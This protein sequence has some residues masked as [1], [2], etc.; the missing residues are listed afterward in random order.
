[1]KP[2]KLLVF[3]SVIL[4][5]AGTSFLEQNQPE[6][7][8]PI[9]HEQAMERWLELVKNRFKGDRK[10]VARVFYQC[11]RKGDFA[12]NYE[13]LFATAGKS[14]YPDSKTILYMWDWSL[15]NGGEG[16]FVF[17]VSVEGSPPIITLANIG[18]WCR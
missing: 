16:D 4:V 5:V 2:M 17:Q 3:L 7:I 6:P 8:T 13:T 11:F 18:E 9:S 1:M 10:E 12:S 15:G 14:E